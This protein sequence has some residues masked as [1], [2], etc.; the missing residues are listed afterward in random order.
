MADFERRRKL[1][2]REQE[3]RRKEEKKIRWNQK[4][5]HVVRVFFIQFHCFPPPKCV[6]KFQQHSL[7]SIWI[8]H[9]FAALDFHCAVYS[10][11]T[12]KDAQL[13]LNIFRFRSMAMPY[14]RVWVQMKILKR[15]ELPFALKTNFHYLLL[16]R[17]PW[18]KR[19]GSKKKTH[20][21]KMR[22]TGARVRS[23]TIWSVYTSHSY[24]T[25]FGEVHH[26]SLVQL[27]SFERETR[28]KVFMC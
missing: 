21:R 10:F 6:S 23:R 19:S 15:V 1:K 13:R 5:S 3:S 2:K 24:Y 11:L 9:D 22:I 18:R 8:I 20:Q 27:T 25:V 4:P 17:S 16:G 12:H 14:I 28:K 26:I 7:F